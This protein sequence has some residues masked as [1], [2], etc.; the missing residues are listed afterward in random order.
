MMTAGRLRLRAS[1]ECMDP[2]LRHGDLLHLEPR[3]VSEIAV[4]DVVAFRRAGRLVAHRA[5]EKGIAEG[6]AYVVTRSDR[7][8][9]GNDGTLYDRDVL[10]VVAWIERRGRRLKPRAEGIAGRRGSSWGLPRWR[11]DGKL[12]SWALRAL[13]W[14]QS[15]P[16]YRVGA[17]WWLARRQHKLRYAVYAPL[18]AGQRYDL[19]R[20]LSLVEF[21]SLSL[22]PEA[23]GVD[24]WTLLVWIGSGFRPAAW[25]EMI[26]HSTSDEGA[27]WTVAAMQVRR[28]FRGAGVDH[29]LEAQ[30]AGLL[31]QRDMSLV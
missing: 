19:Y 7:A 26:T 21:A 16:V 25:A 13:A 27:A 31:A 23:G 2:C 10:G 24:R 4:G 17:H 3:R 8:T 22:L 18:H 6:G 11:W 1:G 29:I 15:V 12:R 28:R 14:M 9:G 30:A 5:I 20:K